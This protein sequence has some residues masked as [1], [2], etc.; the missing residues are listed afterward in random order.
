MKSCSKCLLP[1]THETIEFDENS[2]CNVCKGH[3]FKKENIDWDKKKN[4]FKIILEK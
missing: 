2:K 4:D 3:E 1:E